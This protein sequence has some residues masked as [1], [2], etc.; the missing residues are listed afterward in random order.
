MK[1]VLSGELPASPIELPKGSH[2]N[3]SD[4]HVTCIINPGESGIKAL[5]TQGHKAP[6]SFTLRQP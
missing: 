3:A 6:I 5:R 2:D 4:G 1:T